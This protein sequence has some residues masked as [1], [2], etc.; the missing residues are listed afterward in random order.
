MAN[1]SNARELIREIA[2]IAPEVQALSRQ[3][4]DLADERLGGRVIAVSDEGFG[5]AQRILEAQRVHRY[6]FGADGYRYVDGWETRRR[7]S[8][9]SEWCEIRLGRPGRIRGIVIDTSFFTGNY[10]MA[11]T[12]EARQ[13]GSDDWATVLPQVAL[14]GHAQRLDL[15]EDPATYSHVRLSIHP[16]G[17]LARLRVFGEVRIDLPEGEVDL[18]ALE[19]GGRAVGANDAHFAAPAQMISPEPILDWGKGWE[20]RRRREPGHDWAVLVLARPGRITRVEVD[21]SFYNGNQPEAISLQAAREDVRDPALLLN[22]AMFWPQILPPQK[23]EGGAHKT[24]TA[25]ILDHSPVT[26]VR[27]NIHPDG[28]ITRLRLF[29]RAE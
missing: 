15:V 12:V 1:G 24:I 22:Q 23:I 7:R 3:W 19:N 5:P 29:G 8:A 18:A 4:T 10:P 2:E 13:D 11:A 21:T 28:G 14:S 16:D 6:W 9:G 27:V 26:H 20:T 17:G 25:E